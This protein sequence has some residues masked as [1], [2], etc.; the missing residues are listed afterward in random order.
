VTTEILAYCRGKVF[1]HIPKMRIYRRDNS[2]LVHAVFLFAIA[3][4]LDPCDTNPRRL[5]KYVP[6]LGGRDASDPA[7]DAYVRIHAGA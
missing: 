4:S 5:L 6:T 2:V 1:M 7:L 3:F